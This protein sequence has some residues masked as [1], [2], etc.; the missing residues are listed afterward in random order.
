MNEDRIIINNSKPGSQINI[1][2]D[3][4]VINASQTIIDKDGKK[5]IINNSGKDKK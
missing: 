1:G 5:T 4:A 3:N 2:R